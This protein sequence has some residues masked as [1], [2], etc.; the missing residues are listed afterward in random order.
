MIH[1]SKNPWIVI[2]ANENHG[3]Y[4]EDERTGAT[5]CDFYIMKSG[6]LF[7]DKIPYFEHK[8]ALA[9]ANHIVELHNWSVKD[10]Y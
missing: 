5:I 6:S 4:I 7:H 8:S 3:T 2:K 9:H 10:D 1:E